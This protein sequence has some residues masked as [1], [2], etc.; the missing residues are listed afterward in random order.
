MNSDNSKN[1]DL[2]NSNVIITQLKDAEQFVP[3]IDG[4]LLYYGGNQSWFE[5][6]VAR[7]GACGTVVGSNIAAYMAKNNENYSDLYAYN[8]DLITKD[9]FIRHLN[10][11]YKY[12]KPKKIITPIG[13][14]AIGIWPL[15]YFIKG[16]ESFANSRSVNLKAQRNNK[17]YT[18]ENVKEYIKEGLKINSPVALMIGFNSKTKDIEVTSPNLISRQKMS[19][20]WVT[21]TAIEENLITNK[22][23]VKVSTWGGYA[24]IDLNDIIEGEKLY[25]SAVYFK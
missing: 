23:T 19:W 25:Q 1:P 16:F 2:L 9:D 11:V 24:E 5:S 22:T 8:A 18:S 14:K 3:I 17:E 7:N 12:I 6:K 15:D 20:H 10:E 21:I 4:E 13:I